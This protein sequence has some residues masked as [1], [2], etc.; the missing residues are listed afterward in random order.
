MLLPL[1]YTHPPLQSKEENGRNGKN[2]KENNEANIWTDKCFKLVF[3]NPLEKEQK[4]EAYN[5]DHKSHAQH[6]ENEWK[7]ILPYLMGYRN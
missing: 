3:R 1:S 6:G 5:R 4:I 7:I 2:R